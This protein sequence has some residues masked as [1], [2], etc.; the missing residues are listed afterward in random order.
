MSRLKGG[1]DTWQNAIFAAKMCLSVL[2]FPIR[3]DVQTELGNLMLSAL[4]QLLTVLRAGFTFAL[5]AFVPE[6]LHALSK[7][8]Y[9]IKLRGCRLTAPLIFV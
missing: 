4:R 9:L 1:A 8:I 7:I 3:T 6:R 2:R 5:A